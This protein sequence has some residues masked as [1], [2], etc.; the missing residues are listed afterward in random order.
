M[1]EV[2]GHD[3][4]IYVVQPFTVEQHKKGDFTFYNPSDPTG[5]GIVLNDTKG[6]SKGREKSLILPKG[7]MRYRT[8]F[9]DSLLIIPPIQMTA[10]VSYSATK[11]EG[12]GEG[13]QVCNIS[14]YN[15]SDQ[16]LSKIKTG[17]NLILNAGYKTEA[18]LPI[19]FCGDI[20]SVITNKERG[21]R[22][23]KIVVEEGKYVKESITGK[24]VFDRGANGN[25]KYIDML[26]VVAEY[27]RNNNISVDIVSDDIKASNYN[28]PNDTRLPVRKIVGIDQGWTER[29]LTSKQPNSNWKAP[30]KGLIFNGNVFT[31]LTSIC[32]EIDHIW[33]F[34]KGVLYIRHKSQSALYDSYLITPDVVIG[35]IAYYDEKEGQ[36][37]TDDKQIPS[38]NNQG[39]TFTTF[40]NSKISL[41]NNIHISYSMY[42]GDYVVTE[43]RHELN[44]HSSPWQSVVK[45]KQ[46]SSYN[47]QKEII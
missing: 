9:D 29:R 41:E 30:M 38:E 10:D 23:T 36:T 14:L 42:K 12:S 40:F 28:V 3:Y 37:T 15:L 31:T 2:Y 21:S 45:C 8:T 26:N 17:Y 7:Y 35:N 34:S 19:T 11:Q 6:D 4:R 25:L 16:T 46:S 39:V 44:W 47:L 43:V 22:V 5:K 13:K 32:N 20:I 1:S 33:F 27:I 24:F 18:E